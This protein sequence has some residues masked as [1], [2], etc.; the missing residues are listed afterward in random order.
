MNEVSFIISPLCPRCGLPF[1]IEKDHD[2]LCGG[3]LLEDRP[4]AVARSV[5]RYEGTILKAV[6][7]FK[8]QGKTGIGKALGN[9]MADF[10]SGIWKMGTFDMVMPVPLHIRRLRERG[11]NQSVI[12]A[13]QLSRRF[14]IPLDFSS[15]KRVRFTPSQVGMGR[16]ERAVNVMGAFALTKHSDI[17]G[18]KILLVDDVY[19]T[20]STLIECSQVL[21]DSGAAAVAVL[22]MARAIGEHL[23]EEMQE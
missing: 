22:T 9:V 20:G 3:C 19:T 17:V 4:Y 7:K 13:R 1:S 8:Y 14:H 6:H 10:A 5:C 15:L 16:K 2:H 11:F 21:I 12:L 18:K 23:S